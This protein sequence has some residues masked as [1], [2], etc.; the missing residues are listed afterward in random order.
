MIGKLLLLFPWT[1]LVLGQATQPHIV[2]IVVDDLGNDRRVK[3]LLD[4]HLVCN[5]RME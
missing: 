3:H 4:C 1:E 2:T 5:L